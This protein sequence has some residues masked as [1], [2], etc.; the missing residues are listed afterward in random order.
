MYPVS[1]TERKAIS[2]ETKEGIIVRQT[3]VAGQ[4]QCNA[5]LIANL[6]TKKAVLIDPGGAVENIIGAANQLGVQ[7]EE[8]YHTH[9]HFDHIL[10]SGEV[11]TATKARSLIHSEDLF[12]W[13]GLEKQMKSFGLSGQ[14]KAHQAPDQLLTDGHKMNVAGINGVCI[15]TPGHTKGSTSYYF[16]DINVVCTGDTLFKMNIGRTDLIDGNYEEIERS[17]KRKLYKLKDETLVI[18]G[19]GSFTSIG[20]EK[21]HNMF[22]KA[23]GDDDDDDDNENG[24]G[25][26]VSSNKTSASISISQLM[27]THG[28]FIGFCCHVLNDCSHF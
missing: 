2:Y 16:P 25:S 23:S 6:K 1:E 26:K 20:F 19:H 27:K 21:Q 5:T 8:I 7:I 9:G 24:N 12:W 18:P 22:F 28:R 15:H 10:C 13:N 14:I 17:I 4:M 11:K 3:I